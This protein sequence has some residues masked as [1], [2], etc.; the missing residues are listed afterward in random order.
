MTD[1]L[2]TLAEAGAFLRCRDPRTA[3]K[4]LDVLG[5]PVV[6]IGRTVLVRAV[7]LERGV[8]VA[9]RVTRAGASTASPAGVVL[10]RGARLWDSP[11]A[12]PNKEGPR[13][14]NGR[15]RGTGSA[16]AVRP[17]RNRP[18]DDP[19]SASVC[20]SIARETQR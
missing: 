5:V 1:H 3:R 18:V 2:L 20:P 7:D 12:G 11:G 10:A 8:A 17:Q 19:S 15:P 6:S 4:R 14:A 9:A 16:P 13:R